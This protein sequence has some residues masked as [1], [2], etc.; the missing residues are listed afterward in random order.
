MFYLTIVNTTR[1]HCHSWLA[2]QYME[3]EA[4]IPLIEAPF[5]SHLQ[6][7]G[8]SIVRL[9]HVLLLTYH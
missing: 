9:F 1:R 3:S 5:G 4:E 8:A 2:G 6:M 7:T